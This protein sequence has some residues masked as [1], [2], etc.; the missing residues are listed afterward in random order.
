MKLEFEPESK[1][2]RGRL[3]LPSDV[4]RGAHAT[5]AEAAVVPETDRI[6]LR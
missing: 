6:R 2:R 5:T 4:A 3:V 1:T